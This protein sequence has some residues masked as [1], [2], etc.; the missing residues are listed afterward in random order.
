MEDRC[1]FCGEIIPEGVQVCPKCMVAS[2]KKSWRVRKQKHFY[3]C[4]DWFVFPLA[5]EWTKDIYLYLNPTPRLA[6]HFMWWHWQ[7][8]FVKGERQ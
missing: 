3:Y 1:I 5:I 7:W 8:T 2:K 4:K 6:I